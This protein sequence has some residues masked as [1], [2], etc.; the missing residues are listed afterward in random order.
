MRERES[1]RKKAHGKEEH[2]ESEMER[3]SG[4]KNTEMREQRERKG[5]A[6]PIKVLIG[7]G[8]HITTGCSASL[9]DVLELESLFSSL[10]ND[11][12]AQQRN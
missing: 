8:R 2:I 5:F 11:S 12:P 6:L 7:S 3:E 9:F 4:R 1:E 10:T